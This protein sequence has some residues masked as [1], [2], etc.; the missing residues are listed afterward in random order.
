MSIPDIY[1]L[2]YIR[3]APQ[4]PT[5]HPEPESSQAGG[6]NEARFYWDGLT[7]LGRE[8]PVPVVA[9]QAQQLGR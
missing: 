5:Y 7:D 9:V 6:I 1:N 8:V 2:W 3:G 4:D